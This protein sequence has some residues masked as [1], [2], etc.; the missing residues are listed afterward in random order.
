MS[1]AYALCG[2]VAF[3]GVESCRREGEGVCVERF[4][5]ECGER[6]YIRSGSALQAA[7]RVKEGKIAM[8]RNRL[9]LP[10]VATWSLNPARRELSFTWSRYSCCLGIVHLSQRL[11]S[12]THEKVHTHRPWCC[13]S[14]CWIW[15]FGPGT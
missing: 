5:K 1:V 6:V 15:T 7:V 4:G 9:L 8:E 11:V 14:G 3:G 13:G 10:A 12:C 2:G